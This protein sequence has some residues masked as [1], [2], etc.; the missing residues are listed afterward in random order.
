MRHW[1]DYRSVRRNFL[2][3]RG[4]IATWRQSPRYYHQGTREARVVLTGD[5]FGKDWLPCRHYVL[6]R[7]QATRPVSNEWMARIADGLRRALQ[8]NATNG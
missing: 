4:L 7:K 5:E 8:G 1:T 6:Q 3:S 2:R